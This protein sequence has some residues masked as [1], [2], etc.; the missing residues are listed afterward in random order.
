MSLPSLVSANLRGA[1]TASYMIIRRVGAER[2][3]FHYKHTMTMEML[4]TSFSLR[5]GQRPC[6]RSKACRR[7]QQTQGPPN[8]SFSYR[9][10]PERLPINTDKSVCFSPAVC[11]PRKSLLATTAC[12]SPN[13]TTLRKA[14]ASRS[15]TNTRRVWLGTGSRFK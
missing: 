13:L 6:T 7:P 15:L 8:P 9:Q 10:F 5:R 4:M 3:L 2:A 11:A 12:F 1:L 14:S